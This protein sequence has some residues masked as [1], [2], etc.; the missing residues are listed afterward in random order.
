MPIATGITAGPVIPG[1]ALSGGAEEVVD[2]VFID[3]QSDALS[4]GRAP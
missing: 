4:D 3:W 1:G 2:Q